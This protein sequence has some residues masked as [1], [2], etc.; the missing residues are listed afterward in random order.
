MTIDELQVQITANSSD[1]QKEIGKVKRGLEKLTNE[2]EKNSQGFRG[3]MKRMG[4]GAVALGNVIAGVVSKAVQA[5]SMHIG[6]AIKR[7]DTIKNYPRVMKSLGY[8]TSDAEKS[9]QMLSDRLLGLPTSLDNMVSATQQLAV[10]SP[11]L[12]S[13]TERALALNN[14]LLAGGQG[15]EGAS[16]G[17]RQFSQMLATGKADMQSW[18]I[19]TEVMPGQLS[20]VAKSMLGASANGFNLQEALQEGKVTMQDFADQVV[21]LNKDGF[22]GF[23][24][25]EE[26]ARSATGGVGTS[27]TNMKIAFVR[28]LASIMDSI[29]QTNIAN[30]FNAISSA[31]GRVIPY[32]VAFVQTIIMAV[33]WVSRLF[34]SSG[35]TGKELEAKTKKT[36]DNLKK[37]ANEAG[38]V[39]DALG[40][41]GEE[42]KKLNEALSGFDEMTVLTEKDSGS[43]SGGAGGG[44]TAGGDAIEFP[45]DEAT[46]ELSKV[47]QILNKLMKNP[48][49]KGFVHVF[50]SVATAIKFVIEKA[51]EFGSW[52]AKLLPEPVANFFKTIADNQVVGEILEKV[53]FYLGM[54]AGALTIGAIAF[55]IWTTVTAIATGVTAVFGAVMGLTISPI[56]LIVAGI[57]LVIGA[58]MLL[59]KNFDKI[60]Y[61]AKY[62]WT[63]IQEA[64]ANAGKWFDDNVVTPIK[65][66]FTGLWEWIKKYAPIILL[67]IVAPWL[68]AVI[69]IAKNFDKIKE[70][71]GNLWQGIKNVFSGIADWFGDKFSSAYQS[72]KNAFGAV[73]GFF[74]G[75]WTKIKEKF[76][77][78][79]SSI[80]DAMGGAFKNVVNTVLNFA[81]NA[82]NGF[83][84]AINGAIGAIN[85]I[86]GVSIGKLGEMSIPRLA[87]GGVIDNATLAILGESGREAVVPLENNTGWINEIASQLNGVGGGGQPINLT[88]KIGEETIITKM[89]DGIKDREYMT[90]QEVFI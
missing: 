6:D 32:V 87:R 22:D 45:A 17:M 58:V 19:L 66:F 72:V 55:G 80:G 25:F 78:I 14:A 84:R 69:A 29:G 77:S 15:A 1:F 85:K 57:A 37:S 56:L 83:I 67:A 88:V 41:A 60:S 53:G 86:P 16:R 44:V 63:K 26:Q 12:A 7:L 36:T 76:S 20:Q 51:K 27:I 30:F 89:I 79:G 54:V 62:V 9:I 13:A 23:G 33:S 75:I 49:V 21:K 65:D 42:A 34:G 28:G 3:A 11:T 64:W 59:V 39:G 10:M 68:L 46:K 50:E 2:A 43:G 90:N 5:F 47:Q 24:S 38:S 74:G 18:K 82:I 31:I 48:F 73:I 35:G 61:V 40:G 8:A 81:E 4:V 52:L 71:A 70:F